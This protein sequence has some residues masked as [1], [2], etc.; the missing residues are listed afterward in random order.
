MYRTLISDKNKFGAYSFNWNIPVQF[1]P[2][3]TEIPDRGFVIS[4]KVTPSDDTETVPVVAS[5]L[6]VTKYFYNIY[7]HFNFCTET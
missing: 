5:A 4:K 3:K 2:S 7:I 1:V 6:T